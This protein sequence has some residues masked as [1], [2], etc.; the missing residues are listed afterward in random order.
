MIDCG[1][2]AL[3]SQN[4]FVAL[5]PVAYVSNQGSSEVKVMAE[6]SVPQGIFDKG[7]YEFMP[8]SSQVRCVC[9]SDE[10]TMR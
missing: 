4:I 9:S 3:R 7:V 8:S 10:C 5:A 1:L 6:L 2:L